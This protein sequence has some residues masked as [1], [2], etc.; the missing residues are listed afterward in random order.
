M[1]AG[2]IGGVI[3]TKTG[4]Y[5]PLHAAAYIILAIGLGISSLLDSTSS[6]AKWAIFQIVLALG[7]GCTFVTLLPAIQAALPES[8]VATATATY[9]FFRSFGF[10]WGV[11][12]PSLILNSR[13][14]KG[15]D[16]VEDANVRAQL[17]NG[18]AYQFAADGNVQA[19]PSP[20]YEE[21][22]SIYTD[23]FRITWLAALAFA[24]MGFLLV[25]LEKHVELRQELE[26]EF[27]L[28]NTQKSDDDRQVEVGLK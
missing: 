1:P 3:M 27:G 9:S 26:T 17:A 20:V 21:V 19:L 14:T 2:M 13:I 11:T 12:I 7:L 23:T 15:L 22:I 24:L 25:F 6:T 10:I 18:G 16:T 8:D 28:E 4:V 5:R